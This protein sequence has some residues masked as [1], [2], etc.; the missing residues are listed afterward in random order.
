MTH[1]GESMTRSTATQPSR[2]CREFALQTPDGSAHVY[3]TLDVRPVT[4]ERYGVLQGELAE[5]LTEDLLPNIDCLPFDDKKTG[6]VPA[7]EERS[8][9]TPDGWINVRVKIICFRAVDF[10]ALFEALS[11]VL[12][13]LD[14][15]VFLL[16]EDSEPNDDQLLGPATEAELGRNVRQRHADLRHL[17][18]P[19][20]HVEP[21][22]LSESRVLELV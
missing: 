17:L 15:L 13:D 9:G 1:K 19:G 8:F 2:I 22:A 6:K 7:C 3:A 14:G 5:M 18:P 21:H 20:A 16:L 10:L 11:D 4:E 12:T